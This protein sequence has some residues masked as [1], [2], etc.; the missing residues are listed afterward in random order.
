MDRIPP[1][2]WL[3]IYVCKVVRT[4]T[5]KART[6]AQALED[7]AWIK[8]ITGPTIEA[9]RQYIF[10]WHSVA[11]CVLHLGVEDVVTIHMALLVCIRNLLCARDMGFGANGLKS[12]QNSST[13]VKPEIKLNRPKTFNLI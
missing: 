12:H 4:R 3:L 7:R 9:L 2:S 1:V 11:D 10:L 6:V 8:D 5:V 13:S